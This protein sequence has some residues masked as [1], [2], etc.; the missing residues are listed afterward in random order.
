MRPSAQHDRAIQESPFN[1]SLPV[2]RRESGG[3]LYELQRK[4]ER[5]LAWRCVSEGAPRPGTPA[6]SRPRLDATRNGAKRL[7]LSGSRCSQ[8]FVLRAH[9]DCH[10]RIR[11]E[12]QATITQTCQA[13]CGL[14]NKERDAFPQRYSALTMGVSANAHRQI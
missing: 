7:S 12:K 11:S 6:C 5:A 13:L 3:G 1:L 9:T 2:N 8:P 14:S 4:R 10:T